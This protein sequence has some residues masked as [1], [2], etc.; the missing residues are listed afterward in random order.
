M[1]FRSYQYKN[2]LLIE[3][4]A[5]PNFWRGLLNN[6]KN[7]DAIWRN[8]GDSIEVNSI[9]V[10]T[11]NQNQTELNV[12]LVFPEL[13]GVTYNIIYTIDGSGALTVDIK[14]DPSKY[15]GTYSNSRM[16][17]V[18]TEFIL[19][20]GFEQVDWFG[21]GPVETLTDRNAGAIVGAYSSTV[22]EMFYPY[23]DTQ[24]TGTLTGT[25]WISVTSKQSKTAVAFTSDVDFESS[26]LHFT[27][28][29]L[30]AARHPYELKPLENTILSVN[31]LSSGA[32]NA[33][34]GPDTLS[35]YTMHSNREY[36]YS[37]TI[38]PYTVNKSLGNIPAYVSEVTRQYRSE[39]TSYQY[40]ETPDDEL[41]FPT[42][43][44]QPTTSPAPVVTPP[45]VSPLEVPTTSL[46]KPS[47][48]LKLTGAYKKNQVTL[49]WKKVSNAS[50]Y[51][52]ARSLKKNKGYKNIKVLKKNSKIKYVDKKV[53][54]N[55][56]YYYKIR[57]YK[58]SGNKKQYGNYSKTL[59]IKIKK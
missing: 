22:N 58:L 55:K 29:D 39:A 28:E 50:G 4:G 54:A 19:P 47:K 45:I 27:S 18:G 21:N 1:L 46:K 53:K 36:S 42:S 51:T 38:V 6:D 48:V 57:A 12:S 25:K 41:V 30:T 2:E 7:Y 24:D 14:F 49:K 3:Q 15:T 59:R 26:A 32:G 10:T 8:I 56:T 35:Q 40:A 16:L 33:S 44:P 13:D 9:D 34:C 37:F 23:M 20:Q 17:R 5:K 31:N 11:N 43:T 52:I